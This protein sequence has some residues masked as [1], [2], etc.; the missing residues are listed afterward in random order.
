MRNNY[1]GLVLFA[2]FCIVL[3]FGI[4]AFMPADAPRRT[5]HNFEFEQVAKAIND[6]AS[7]QIYDHGI[8]FGPRSFIKMGSPQ[9]HIESFTGTWSVEDGFTA[10]I[11]SPSYVLVTLTA[12]GCKPMEGFI[13]YDSRCAGVSKEAWQELWSKARDLAGAQM[14]KASARSGTYF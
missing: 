13:S 4:M 3:P 11:V 14:R 6:P 8:P 10:K 9:R 1:Q 7:W 5:L 12:D 2:F